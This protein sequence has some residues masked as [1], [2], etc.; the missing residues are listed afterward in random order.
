MLLSFPLQREYRSLRPPQ[1]SCSFAARYITKNREYQEF[2]AYANKF[3]DCNQINVWQKLRYLTAYFAS[4]RLFGTANDLASAPDVETVSVYPHLEKM[5]AWHR[6]PKQFLKLSPPDFYAAFD[7]VKDQ[8]RAGE[9]REHYAVDFP[10]T[11]R[12]TRTTAMKRK[13]FVRRAK[14]K[15]CRWEM[16]WPT[17][18][19]Y[20]LWAIAQNRP[21]LVH[22][23]HRVELMPEAD[24]ETWRGEAEARGLI[25]GDDSFLRYSLKLKTT[26]E[27]LQ[28]VFVALL[29]SGCSPQLPPFWQ[30]MISK[31]NKGRDDA[32]Q[33]EYV[34]KELRDRLR[35]HKKDPDQH[36]DTVPRSRFEG[37]RQEKFMHAIRPEDVREWIAMDESPDLPKNREQLHVYNTLMSAI[38]P[39]SPSP[40]RKS[41]SKKP[42]K[43]APSASRRPA[44]IPKRPKRRTNVRD[45]LPAT[46][47]M[48]GSATPKSSKAS[49]RLHVVN[50]PAGT[51]KTFLCN[52]IIARAH[53]AG[54]TVL[55][56]AKSHAAARLLLG[57][58]TMHS[59]FSLPVPCTEESDSRVKGN[60]DLLENLTAIVF[61]EMS[62]L[63]VYEMA[64]I[65]RLLRRVRNSEERFGGVI[66]VFLGDFRQ[67]LTVVPDATTE[68]W[69]PDRAGTG[70]PYF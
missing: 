24:Y 1:W 34:C 11:V 39:P 7:L 14:P 13:F 28:E 33:Y 26:P 42:A 9:K 2:A 32:E 51:G 40:K 59:A 50:A 15:L 57:G 58:M 25:I 66:T 37:A 70:R 22:T 35:K 17:S 49:Q 16:P 56:V 54:Y 55:P 67:I 65:D 10:Y 31:S 68:E 3:P 46:E 43:K 38:I 52:C 18:P 62:Q 48:W 27:K 36:L 61:D 44:A 63:D 69:A 21:E 41:A 45:V 53:Q 8:Q 23:S 60:D 4:F 30:E 29:E 20:G 47:I 6:R 19:Y 64:A 12:N 5:A